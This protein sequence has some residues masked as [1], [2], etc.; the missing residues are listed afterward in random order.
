M[1]IIV[2]EGADGTGK[3]TLARA[4]EKCGFEYRH[5]G[6]PA[7]DPFEVYTR[8][9]LSARGKDVVFD[10][11]H[12]GEL[13]YGPV[14]RGRSLITVEQLRLLNRLLFSLGGKVIL[15][16]TDDPSIEKNWL[17]RRGEEYLDD[18]DKLYQVIFKY[19]ELVQQ[20][21]DTE[22]VWVY[23][24]RGRGGQFLMNEIEQL[25]VPSRVQGD[26]CPPGVI[27][28]PRNKFLFIGERVNL[29]LSFGQDLAFYTTENS[30]GFFNRCLW[31][32]GYKEH[33]VAFTNAL[34]YEGNGRDLY[35]I[36]ALNKEQVVITLGKWADESCVNQAVPH[37]AAPHPQYI[38]RFE[39]KNRGRYVELLNRFRGSC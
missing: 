14:M 7:G 20:E 18:G 33:E 28:R 6:P 5:Q 38:K 22:D 11:L 30:A 35:E 2:I 37:L 36:W 8:E 19:R 3:T 16:D 17:A 1:S 25:G 12:V 27:G 32:A 10:R 21:L 15:C 24:Y 23:D 13:V 29:K 31:D 9:L 4:L 39:L 26:F 34:D